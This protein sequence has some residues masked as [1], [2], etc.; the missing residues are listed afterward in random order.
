MFISVHMTT[1]C[2]AQSGWLDRSIRSVLEQSH[3]DL[4][5]IIYDDGSY[6]GTAEILE[7]Y[8]LS[9]P[10]VRIITSEQNVNSVAKSLGRCFLERSPRAEAITWMFDDNILRP[11]AIERLTTAMA[12]H[13]A[14]VVY[15]Q[16]RIHYDQDKHWDIGAP[17]PEHIAKNFETSSAQVPN[18]G[19][20]IRP[21]VFALSGW[22]DANIILRRSCDWDLFRR[23]WKTA[24]KIVR[25]DHICAEEFGELSQS[26]LRNSF[27]TTFELMAKYVTLR[28]EQA[29]RLDPLAV[30]YGPADVIPHG[31]WTPQELEYI[32]RVFVRYFVSIAD[33]KQ[34]AQWA[35][36]LLEA[37]GRDDLVVRNL[38]HRFGDRPEILDAVFAGMFT[39]R[40][41]QAAALVV[42]SHQPF[43]R[44][45]DAFLKR[46]IRDAAS[47]VERKA[48]HFAQRTAQLAWR[49][50]PRLPR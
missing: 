48:W 4:E 11:D 45:V 47:G 19:I 24:G 2:Q 27:D 7:R 6:D 40:M 15:G 17:T 16:T 44:R 30:V 26:S 13:N 46:R 37:G 50:R 41:T 32:Y 18:A 20:L 35:R 31:H 34:G 8:R 21:G 10:R 43:V 38:N 12:T 14:D 9:D 22:Y 33:V 29:I 42:D 36:V 28:D 39:P 1:F 3:S 49:L 5:L 23:I 25:I